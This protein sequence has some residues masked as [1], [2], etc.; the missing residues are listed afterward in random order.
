M[1]IINASWEKRNLSANTYEVEFEVGD[2]NEYFLTE[3]NKLFNAEYLVVKVPVGNFE[4]NN[5]LNQNDF[6]FAE[7]IIKIGISLKDFVL[8]EKLDKINRSVSYKLV[9]GD[10]IDF[11]CTKIQENIFSTDRIALDKSFGL[12]IANKRYSNWIKDEFIQKNSYIFELQFGRRGIGFFGLKERTEQNME[13]F[14]GGMYN[15]VKD[16]GLGFG[17]ISK[18][19]EETIAREFKHLYTHVSTNNIEVLRLYMKL[20]FYPLEIKNV[21]IK[22]LKLIKYE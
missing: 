17:M 2:E 3:F 15:E 14:L 4:L 21:F 22:H 1:K 18:S 11:I 20:G 12:A 19:I 5:C 13:I 6:H 10:Q 9:E 16:F 7:S 8:P